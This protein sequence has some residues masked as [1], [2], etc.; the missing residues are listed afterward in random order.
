[1]LVAPTLQPPPFTE[2]VV[3][4]LASHTGTYSPFPLSERP[5]FLSANHDWEFD[6]GSPIL[7]PLEAAAD[8]GHLIVRISE[9]WGEEFW[10]ALQRSQ[11]AEWF[12]RNEFLPNVVGVDP[13]VIGRAVLQ[14]FL[15]RCLDRRRTGTPAIEDLRRHAELV[16]GVTCRSTRPW[17]RG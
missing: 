17:D 13:S 1:M 5:S 12:A 4:H 2:I 16:S 14:G 8:Q 10:I 7:E 15:A 11:E 6:N 3:E 9:N